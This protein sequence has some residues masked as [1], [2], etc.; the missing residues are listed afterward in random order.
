MNYTI[1]STI[2]GQILRNIATPDISIQ[3]GDDEDYIDGT[4]NDTEY[5]IEQGQAVAI[6]LKPGEYYV[7]NY[8]TKQWQQ[9]PQIAIGQVTARRQKLL[10]QSDWTELPTVIAQRTEQWSLDWQQYRQALRDITA[11]PGYPTNIMW[12]VAPSA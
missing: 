12:P 10:Q 5:Y 3:I 8:T 9:N 1:Y 7:F 6:P 11:Q 2:T 4:I